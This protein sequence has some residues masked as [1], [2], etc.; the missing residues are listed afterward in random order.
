[1]HTLLYSTYLTVVQYVQHVHQ[2]TACH[3]LVMKKTSSGGNGCRC[4]TC[5]PTSKHTRD[6]WMNLQESIADI[7]GDA[8]WKIRGLIGSKSANS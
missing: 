3:I 6:V 5:S 4:R 8:S 2:N 7:F 1:M